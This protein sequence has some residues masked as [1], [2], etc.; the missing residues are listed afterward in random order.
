MSKPSELN[1][2]EILAGAAMADSDP[3]F[4]EFGEHMRRCAYVLRAITDGW[5]RQDINLLILATTQTKK[6]EKMI[7]RDKA[8][9]KR[10]DELKEK[11]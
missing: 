5:I 1:D 9:M 10:L 2:L 11:L 8:T 3:I 4:K 6:L 7:R